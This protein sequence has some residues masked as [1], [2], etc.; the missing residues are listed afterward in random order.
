MHSSEAAVVTSTTIVEI[1]ANKSREERAC[2]LCVL[3]FA[4]VFISKTL[5]TESLTR[6]SQATRAAPVAAK[7]CTLY[8]GNV[9]GM[10]RVFPFAVIIDSLNKNGATRLWSSL[11]SPV[12]ASFFFRADLFEESLKNDLPFAGNRT[13]AAT[14]KEWLRDI[15]AH[16]LICEIDGIKQEYFFFSIGHRV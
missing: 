12:C 9:T 8:F 7:K 14:R 5:S 1:R 11:S 10:Y 4:L 6:S 2:V 16:R 15:V 3:C 13:V